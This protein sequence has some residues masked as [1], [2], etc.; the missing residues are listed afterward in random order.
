MKVILALFII[1]NFLS[2]QVPDTLTF[3]TVDWKLLWSKN[4]ENEEV[5]NYRIYKST[6]AP[7]P[8]NSQ[9]GHSFTVPH[10]PRANE[11]DS[12]MQFIDGNLVRGQI[13]YYRL[14]A[15]NEYGVS[16]FSKQVF[17][18]IPVYVG[19][20]DTLQAQ[21]FD[22]SFDLNGDFYDPGFANNLMIWRAFCFNDSIGTTMNAGV[23]TCT[24]TWGWH[25]Y[26]DI[27]VRVE[28]PDEMYEVKK[29]TL[30]L[31]GTYANIP[32]ILRI[33]PNQ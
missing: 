19:T 18:S 2:A 22:V 12:T 10:I 23:L 7:I 16:A 3:G 17:S 29:Y 30:F 13:I 20:R 25:G 15:E 11:A 31:E 9:D 8:I 32:A 21:T 26:Q 24:I 1:F 14:K 28:N 6:G 5:I 27:I 4:A 33:V